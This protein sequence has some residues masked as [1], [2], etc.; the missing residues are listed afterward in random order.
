MKPSG[1]IKFV[2]R[3]KRREEAEN[4]RDLY[5]RMIVLTFWSVANKVKEVRKYSANAAYGDCM[6]S[7]D[8]FIEEFCKKDAA[9]AHL[10]RSA[11]YK[12]KEEIE[13]AWLDYN[14]GRGKPI[15]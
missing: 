13:E 6:F 14:L 5:K 10:I 1:R 9:N 7:W 11:S 2:S 12:A 4:K 15:I 3:E 8:R